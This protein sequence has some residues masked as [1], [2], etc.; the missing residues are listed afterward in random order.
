LPLDGRCSFVTYVIDT[1]Q[2]LG[3]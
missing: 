3:S 1:T 2:W